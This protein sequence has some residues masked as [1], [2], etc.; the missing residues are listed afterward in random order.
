M[1]AGKK[2]AQEEIDFLLDN[3]DKMSDKE[4]SEYLRRPLGGVV[5]MRKRLGRQR[6]Q[7]NR[8]YT[9]ADVVEEFSK[10]NYELVS[11]PE[12]Y[13]DSA[14]NTIKYICPKH[15]LHGVQTISLGHLQSGRG[16]YYCGREVTE[17]AHRVDLNDPRYEELCVS[18]GLM[19]CDVKREK[20]KIWVGFK[21]NDHLDVGVQYMTYDN[22]K[23]P[24]AGCPFCHSSPW[25]DNIRKI[26]VKLDI[27]YIPQKSIDDMVGTHPLRFDFYLPDL[28]K[29]IEYD[30]KHH[31]MPVCFNGVSLS[32]A[33]KE[34]NETL[35]R[36]SIKDDYCKTHDISL[37]RI[38]Y[39]E[40]DK[41]EELIKEFVF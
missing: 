32:I 9:F 7:G 11:G 30:G 3:W 5:S 19:L 6:P 21:C 28:N 23:R 16:C 39:Y 20:G 31:F 17:A 13:Y 37:L 12:D 40:F 36:D 18:K 33:Q 25:E 1:G 14:Q 26:L 4:M 38:P 2:W 22:L 24:H 27:N 10:T 8:K 15:R 29:A 34:Y 41:A 35:R